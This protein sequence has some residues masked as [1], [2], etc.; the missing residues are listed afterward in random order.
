MVFPTTSL[1]ANID[2]ITKKLNAIKTEEDKTGINYFLACLD[3]RVNDQTYPL[4]PPSLHI[5]RNL[6]EQ[7]IKAACS[8]LPAPPNDPPLD[9]F[10]S[11]TTQCHTTNPK[12]AIYVSKNIEAY[13]DQMVSNVIQNLLEDVKKRIKASSV[14]K[15]YVQKLI[16]YRISNMTF[17]DKTLSR[18]ITSQVSVLNNFS[19]KKKQ[20]KAKENAQLALLFVL[21]NK[22]LTPDPEGIKEGLIKLLA[23]RH[24]GCLAYVS[25]FGDFS[26]TDVQDVSETKILTIP[27]FFS[28][29]L[30]L[31]TET[32][33][34]FV[35]ILTQIYVSAERHARKFVGRE[36]LVALLV[37][38]CQI[39]TQQICPYPVLGTV[40]E[41][42]FP[43]HEPTLL[44]DIKGGE[45]RL[46]EQCCEV[47][48][49]LR[50]FDANT[51]TLKY[52]GEILSGENTSNEN[53]SPSNKSKFTLKRTISDIIRERKRSKILEENHETA[54][55]EPL[56]PNNN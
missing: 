3:A 49:R 27:M 56:H 40:I 28:E 24:K 34:I 7:L 47:L 37:D 43:P 6:A 36:I 30:P 8:P 4:P 44:E 31:A 55:R 14:T 15:A 17:D 20:E 9:F 35:D 54:T 12:F 11:T 45:E 18:L 2:E 33:E 50:Q 25:K 38:I 53:A 22:A 16:S 48:Q 23:L 52:D 42:P 26:S 1:H 19:D 46:L 41:P 32:P 29:L 21:F 51:I 10:D 5:S 39:Y 13:A